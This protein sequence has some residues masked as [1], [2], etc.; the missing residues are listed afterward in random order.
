MIVTK[1]KNDG[2]KEEEPK[3]EVPFDVDYLK[4]KKGIPDFWFKA[5]KNCQMLFELVKEKDEEVLLHL[6][7]IESERTEKPKTLTVKLHFN[8]N[9]F[10][11]NSH[12]WLKL[13][14]KND[15]D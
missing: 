4:G 15:G 7:H 12:L 14:Y 11:E 9:D 1:K 13:T 5:V 10:F 8:T 3:P 2:E 6:R